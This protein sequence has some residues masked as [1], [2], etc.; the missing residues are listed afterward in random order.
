MRERILK[1]LAYLHAEYP[2][3]MLFVIVAMTILFM[4]FMSQLTVTMRTSDLLPEK[5]P[6][7]VAFN[8]IIDEF[9]TATNLVIVVQG[10]EERI[11][12]YADE[13]APKILSLRDSTQNAALRE[14]IVE[15]QADIDALKAGNGSTADIE[16]LSNSIDEM[17]SRINFQLFQRVDYK[18][19][20]EFLKDN[21]L[22]LI[23]EDDLKN[24]KETFMDPNLA[25][26]LR[27][28][29][30]SMEKEYV[31]QEESI[32][33]REKEDGAVGFLDGIEELIMTL[34]RTAGGETLEEEEIKRTADQLLFGDPYML[35]YDGTTLLM[36]AVPRFTLMD[37]DYIS[38]AA[39]A[40]QDLVDAQL[41]SY[42]DLY[43]GLTGPIAREHD[44]QTHAQQAIGFTSLIAMIFILIL[45]IISFRMVLSPIF[46]VLTLIV[47]VIWAMGASWLAVGQLNMFTSMMAVVLLGLGI[48]FAIHFISS[49]SEWRAGGDSVHLSLEKA[50]LKSGKGIITGGLTTACA[51]LTLI[52][53]GA[54]GMREMGIV[55]GI[56]IISILMATM[57]AL[58]VM[59]VL[60]ERFKGKFKKIRQRMDSRSGKDISFQFLGVTAEFLSRKWLFTFVMAV[61]VTILLGWSALNI[62]WDDNYMSADPEGWT[63]IALTDTINEKFDLSIEY[64][65]ILV[66]DADQSREISEK[67]R[68]LHSV[69]MTNDI[70]QY[71][72]SHAEQEQRFP[73]IMEIS[74]EMNAAPVRKSINR[75]DL[76]ALKEEVGRLEMNVI[77]MQDMA[78]LGG[79][80]K[81]DRKCS[82]IVG[83]PD[84]PNPRNIIAE[85]LTALE[86]NEAGIMTGLSAFQRSFAPYYKKAVMNMCDTEPIRMESL[87]NSILDQYSNRDRDQFLVTVFPAGDLWHKDILHRFVDDM[88]E[89][90]DGMA[91]GA[92]SLGVSLIRIFGRDGRNAIL[93]TLVIVFILLWIDFKR[94][95]YALTAMI[96]LAV[97]L[98]WMVGL[99]KLIGM[100]LT[101]MNVMGLPM[102]VGIGI[103]DGVHIIHRWLHEGR[104]RVRTVFSSTGKAIFL[105]SLTTAVAF[106]SM[107]FSEFPGWIQFGS[108]LAAGVGACFLATVLILPGMIGFHERK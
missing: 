67:C 50:Y 12:S 97:G 44:E 46:A 79:Q 93:L 101:F 31:G 14:K 20:T 32:S 62:T 54:R 4:V 75:N 36:I 24:M 10:D 74:R 102:I 73:H 56:G 94:P 1:R 88:D 19:E 47:G 92:P 90:S 83:D 15:A 45:L 43:A 40:V 66:D 51:F 100:N 91:T 5:D 34:Q 57:L 9:A 13:L 2:W 60:K 38:V 104:N 81:V 87:P 3:R 30:N 85:L 72:P 17:K 8:K 25:G 86:N 29:N 53:S 82:E 105:T 26:L 35:S 21:L 11:K 42:P 98:L 27:N 108:A 84:D 59:L 37:R 58:P 78:F 65:L 6:R 89:V 7:V 33:T 18:A 64:G 41:E 106:G 61:I 63:S 23:K 103:D 76:E 22:K 95:G 16:A 80:D 39:L 70:T 71:L 28:L 49:F 96:P 99:M 77:E 68:D 55:T 107:V 69:A 48:D 52:I